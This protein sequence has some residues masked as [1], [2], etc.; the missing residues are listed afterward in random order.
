M[1]PSKRSKAAYMSA[2][3]TVI[4]RSESP[5]TEEADRRK[6]EFDSCM[7]II[8]VN[9]RYADKAA[10]EYFFRELQREVQQLARRYNFKLS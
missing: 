8:R 4:K 1:E 7:P 5:G 6:A 3:V 9:I 10:A 2:N